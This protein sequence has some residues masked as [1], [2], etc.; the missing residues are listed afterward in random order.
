MERKFESYKSI[1]LFLCPFFMLQ[2]LPRGGTHHQICFIILSSPALKIPRH[3]SLSQILSSLL[4]QLFHSPSFCISLGKAR[5]FVSTAWPAVSSATGH[6]YRMFRNLFPY[7]SK[8]Q[9][10]FYR[11]CIQSVRNVPF[12]SDSLRLCSH[13][14]PEKE[15]SSREVSMPNV[16]SDF[17]TT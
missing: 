1:I 17:I 14:I 7:F 9:V 8:Q 2:R 10:L 5:L 13:A 4:L 16:G 3:F 15:Y 6:K 12:V 11:P